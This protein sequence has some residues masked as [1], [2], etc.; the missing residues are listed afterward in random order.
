MET[1]VKPVTLETVASLHRT[2]GSFA[3]NKQEYAE[4]PWDCRAYVSTEHHASQNLLV[5]YE[6]PAF[7]PNVE[8]DWEELGTI[9]EMCDKYLHNRAWNAHQFAQGRHY[10]DFRVAVA[11][12]C[13]QPGNATETFRVVHGANIKTRKEWRGKPHRTVCAEMMA[14]GGMLQSLTNTIVVGMVLLGEPRAEEREKGIHFLPPCSD[15]R[16]TMSDRPEF[17]P[18]TRIVCRPRTSWSEYFLSQPF[19]AE[20]GGEWAGTFT[21]IIERFGWED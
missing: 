21:E 13:Y 5:V 12:L 4:R 19:L 2:R 15:C 3:Q 7:D 14:Y 9:F 6:A 17:R 18:E 20:H 11:M 10:N 8:P 16:R 1:I